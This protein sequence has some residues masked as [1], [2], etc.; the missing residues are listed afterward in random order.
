MGLQLMKFQ[1][2][3]FQLSA[4]EAVQPLVQSLS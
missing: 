4:R 1:R 2:M 3:G